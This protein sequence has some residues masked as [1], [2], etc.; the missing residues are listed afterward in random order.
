M[1]GFAGIIDW[2]GSTVDKSSL[3]RMAQQVARHGGDASGTRAGDCFGLVHSALFS[4]PESRGEVQPL[5]FDDTTWIVGDIRIDARDELKDALKKAGRICEPGTPDISLVLH[6]YT[7]WGEDCVRHLLGDFSFAVWNSA[8][9]TLFCARDHFGIKPFYFFNNRNLFIFSNDLNAARSHPLVSGNLDDDAICDYFAFGYNLNETTTSFRDI[10]RVPP[11]NSLTVTRDSLPKFSSY[12]QFT[13]SNRIRYRQESEYSD[14]FLDLFSRAVDDRLRTDRVSF[15]LSGGMDSTSVTALAVHLNRN[16]DR[17]SGLGITTDSSHI[18]PETGEAKFARMVADEAR[19]SHALIEAGKEEDFYAFCSTAQPYA[20]PF[21]ATTQKYAQTARQHANVLIGGQFGDVLF[22]GSGMRVRDEFREMSLAGFVMNRLRAVADKRS[23]RALGIR[24]LMEKDRPL[25]QLPT[26]PDWIR[27]DV[28][29]KSGSKERW[30]ELF[31][32]SDRYPA[33]CHAE[34]TFDEIRLPFWSHLFE[35]YYH[36]LLCGIDCR[37]PFMDLRLLEFSIS[38]P[39]AIKLSKKILRQAMSELLPAP[40]LERPKTNVSQDMVFKILSNSAVRKR[41]PQN[42]A[43][44]SPWVHE[45][46]YLEALQ[47]YARTGQ[48][49]PFTILCPLGLERWNCN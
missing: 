25:L 11:G 14:H 20:W 30:R 15:E 21:A 23:L 6:A 22:Q 1:S 12:R 24:S 48:E 34:M 43:R 46:K 28:L 26:I 4:T 33:G 16:S 31:Y 9:R 13:T 42:L 29:E 41:L 45:K 3:D 39:A 32:G 8:Q 19:I 10:K 38:I 27:A 5:S 47:N 17:F 2:S 49:N 44:S 7:A 40:V 18:F 36:D 35:S 37:Q